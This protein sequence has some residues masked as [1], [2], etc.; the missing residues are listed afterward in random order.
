MDIIKDHLKQSSQI[1]QVALNPATRGLL[2][3][4]RE[5][6][7]RGGGGPVKTKTEIGEM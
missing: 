2:K 5:K 6:D 4:G 3:H 7:K 1:T